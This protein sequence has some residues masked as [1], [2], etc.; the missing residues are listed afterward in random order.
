MNY[1]DL[2]ISKFNEEAATYSSRIIEN[3]KSFALKKRTFNNA[4]D[5]ITDEYNRLYREKKILNGVLDHIQ[6]KFYHRLN[7]FIPEY[8]MEI[9]PQMMLPEFNK[10]ELENYEFK[11]FIKAFAKKNAR[12]EVKKKLSASYNFLSQNFSLKEIENFQFE[13]TPFIGVPT[14]KKTLNELD[15]LNYFQIR[16]KYI[17]L[18]KSDSMYL[19]L[20]EEL[21]DPQ[22]NSHKAIL[23]V[24][25]K[26]PSTHDDV[27]VFE[28]ET[29]IAT[30][31]LKKL[32]NTAFMN[33]R[34]TNISKSKKFLSKNYNPFS[35][36][37]ISRTSK[38]LSDLEQS[39]VDQFIVSLL[40]TTINVKKNA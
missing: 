18:F 21:L 4:N 25:F 39:R 14:V 15:S 3:L 23:N 11:D 30:Y 13:V 20:T 32:G 28:C 31:F 36:S 35:Q 17:A 38:N 34:L 12:I 5:Y 33:F 24:L 27:I 2:Y 16:P 1:I 6:E 22:K 19:K 26:D 9:I 29:K 8:E 10:L 40:N 37:T 7:D